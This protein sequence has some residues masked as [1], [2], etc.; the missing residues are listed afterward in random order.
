MYDSEP[1]IFQ[2]YCPEATVVFKA[3]K[4]RIIFMLD[5]EV[6]FIYHVHEGV[7]CGVRTT[8]QG[9][10]MTDLSVPP[11]LIGVLGFMDMYTNKRRLHLAEA[12]AMTPVV[13]CKVRREAVWDIMDDRKARAEI[14]HLI[15][16]GALYKG[17]LN[18]SPVKTDIANRIL[19]V[20]QILTRSVGKK[21]SDGAIFISD[22]SHEDIAS[23]ANSTRPTVTRIFK[24][25]ERS[26]L[27]TINRR[28]L[29]ILDPIGL[30]NLSQYNPAISNAANIDI[31]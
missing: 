29:I 12:R 8:E 1:C 26:G 23:L 9:H 13:Y 10:E 25:L 19:Y 15:C 31:Q 24:K 7:V 4:G 30:L 22:I 6:R 18:A 11:L 2:R 17:M 27:I 20:L 28:Q 14:I 3:P 21:G 16:K 5:Q